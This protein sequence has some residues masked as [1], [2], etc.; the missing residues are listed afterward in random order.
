M[1]LASSLR[2]LAFA[3]AALLAVGTTGCL[4]V[5]STLV[6]A[7]DGS[8]TL[9]ESTTLDLGKM[10]AMMEGVMGM[11]GGGME[12]APGGAG[13]GGPAGGMGGV[14][15]S[16]KGTVHTDDL[17]KRLEGKTCVTL[18]SVATSEDFEKKIAS[19]EFRLKF[20][21]LGDCLAAGLGSSTTMNVDLSLE[22]GADGSW[23][24]A[25]KMLLPG[26]MEIPDTVPADQAQQVE[27][28]KMML[29]E[30]LGDMSVVW[31]VTV[32]GKVLAT[33]GTKNEAGDTVTWTLGFDDVFNPKSLKQTVT[34]SGEGLTLKPFHVR[35]D[36]EGNP[37]DGGKPTTPPAA[38]APGGEAP[39]EP[40]PPAAPEAPKA[41]DAPKEPAPGGA[42]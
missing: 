5:K 14:G 31:A 32:P 30:Y 29:Q 9:A 42:R 28:F 38:P 7:K 16:V 23:T 17:K 8:G 6:I 19:G 1:T 20:T 4:K 15:K 35:L 26:G 41:P 21:S 25:R 36:Q 10:D 27:M 24:L 39:K 33:N 34:F 3:G 22:Q 18:Q 37:V 40:A 11:L 2:R 12:G 13:G